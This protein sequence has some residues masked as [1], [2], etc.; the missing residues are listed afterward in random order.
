MFYEL[1]PSVIRK[2]KKD[3]HLQYRLNESS[4]FV[5]FWKG[6]GSASTDPYL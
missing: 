3:G 4:G 6:S 5:S 1:K 2:E